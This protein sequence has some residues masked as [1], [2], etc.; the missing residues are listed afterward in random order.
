MG[1]VV[2]KCIATGLEF[3]VGIETDE[4]SFNSLPDIRLKSHC[5][6]CGS[7]HEWSPR[8]ARLRTYAA[9]GGSGSKQELL[10]TTSQGGGLAR[11]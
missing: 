10:E 2:I 3:A 9:L 8:H 5:P 6:H 11:S 1:T 7:D 4:F